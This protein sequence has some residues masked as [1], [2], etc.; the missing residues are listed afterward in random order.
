M[1]GGKP[2]KICY[3]SG[4]CFCSQMKE[5][6]LYEVFESDSEEEEFEDEDEKNDELE[7][8]HNE[9]QIGENIV[10]TCFLCGEEK[11]CCCEVSEVLENGEYAFSDV[12]ERLFSKE[13]LPPRLVTK[14][15]SEGL[16]CAYCKYLVSDLFRLQRELKMCKNIVLKTFINSDK[17]ENSIEVNKRE[18]QKVEKSKQ[19]K[20]ELLIKVSSLKVRAEKRIKTQTLS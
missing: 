13:T 19:Q 14:D 5:S 10:S 18:A 9:D 15:Y 8:G 1:G 12:L 16:L 20:L 3:C 17:E 11:E 4:K 6:N 7:N 2:K